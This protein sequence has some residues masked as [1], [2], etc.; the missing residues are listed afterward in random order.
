MR[1]LCAVITLALAGCPDSSTSKDAP[2]NERRGVANPAKTLEDAK[3]GANKA[4]EAGVQ[5][6]DD[7]LDRAM[8]GETP[9]SRGAM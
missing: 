2:A 3:E 6:N 7:A 5:R 8:E 4:V 1:I 9:K